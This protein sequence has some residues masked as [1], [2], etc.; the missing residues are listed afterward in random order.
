MRH[1]GAAFVKVVKKCMGVDMIKRFNIGQ[2]RFTFTCAKVTKVV[3]VNSEL[4]E[5]KHI[6]MWDFDNVSLDEVVKELR[7]VQ[8][9]CILPDIH[10]LV[11]KEPTNYIAYCFARTDWRVAVYIIAATRLVDWNFF[12]Y[13]VYRGRF[14]LRVSPKQGR[15]IKHKL[16]L[17]G[18]RPPD[19]TIKD[20]KSWVRYETLAGGG[21]K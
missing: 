18:Y 13:G 20:L 19:C 15:A 2:V 10:I 17:K 5:G 21:D 12:K 6:L 14:T 9:D 1:K 8:A 11:T 7:A 3:G 16:T 4:G